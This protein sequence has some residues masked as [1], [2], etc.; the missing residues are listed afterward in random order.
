MRN[1]LA[2][3]VQCGVRAGPAAL[4]CSEAWTHA[5]WKIFPPV[6]A[7]RVLRVLLEGQCTVTFVTLVA[8]ITL[9]SGPCNVDVELKSVEAC[10]SV[11]HPHQNK[12]PCLT[13]WRAHTHTHTHARARARTHT[14]AH[15][16][17]RTG[18]DVKDFAIDMEAQTV[19]VETDMSADD[20]MTIIKKAGKVSPA[21][22]WPRC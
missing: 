7:T 16:R 19:S 21:V 8:F 11:V 15:A 1:C 2:L 4:G 10:V 12:N 5:D 17:T 6:S 3:H 18:A 22:C 9:T 14:R 20:M 13:N